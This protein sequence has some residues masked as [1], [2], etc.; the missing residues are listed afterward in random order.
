[1]KF[2]NI[3][4]SSKKE[5][6]MLERFFWRCQ[7]LRLSWNYQGAMVLIRLEELFTRVILFWDVFRKK[8]YKTAS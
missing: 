3:E 8:I 7:A 2:N 6:G 1:M 5:S 4:S